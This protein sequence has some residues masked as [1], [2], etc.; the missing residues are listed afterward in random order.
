MREAL[1]SLRRGH[2]CLRFKNRNFPLPACERLLEEN[3]H[4][5]A[6]K[7]VPNCHGSKNTVPLKL[8][9]PQ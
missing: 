8:G 6:R 2:L 5:G 1:A 7:T 9:T 4:F 3:E